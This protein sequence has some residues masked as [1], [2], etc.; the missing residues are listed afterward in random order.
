V[1]LEVDREDFTEEDAARF[2]ARLDTSLTVLE[3]LLAR[4]GFGEAPATLGAELEVSLVDAAGAPLLRNRAVLAETLD[5]RLTVELDRFNLESNLRYGPLAGRPFAA[6][7]TE[8]EGALA[9]LGRAAA[10]HGGRIVAVG[11]L[12]TLEAATFEQQVMTESPRYRALSKSLRRLR[13]EPFLL[14]IRGADALHVPCHDVTMEGAANSF[15]LHLRVAPRAF[16]DV[17]NALQLATPPLLAVAG[18]S[19]IFLGRRLWEETRI[20]LFKQAVDHRAAQAH[21]PGTDREPARV[22]FGTRWIEGPH[23]LFEESVRL[24]PPLLPILDA[25]DPAA[26]LR[27]GATPALRELRLHQ[28]TVWRWNRAIYDPAEG[29]HLRVEMRSLPAGP[30]VPDMLANAAFHVGLGLALASEAA[31]WCAGSP[32][33]AVHHDFYRAAREGLAAELGWPREPGAP[34]EACGAAACIE[35]LLPLAQRGLDAAGVERSDSAPRLA[36][37]ERRAR[38]GRTGAAWQRR[39]LAA[40]EAAGHSRP[41]ALAFLLERY[42][43]GAASGEPVDRWPEPKP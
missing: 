24:H 21:G 4:P 10:L 6:L 36:T 26:V 3:A 13:R 25:E 35:A 17:Y 42:L 41:E 22:C 2:A 7:A 9:E 16:A 11:I 15:Q 23:E 1:G 32:F 8:C 37:I 14:D 31:A 27:A 18:N 43:E 28:G 29:G 40:A 5:P 30:S 33:D 12:P 38:S 34:R 20:A 19:P 39:A